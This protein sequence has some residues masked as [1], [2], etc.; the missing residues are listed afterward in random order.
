MTVAHEVILLN[1]YL[2]QTILI[3]LHMGLLSVL[4]R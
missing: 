3:F 1:W 4:Q 2:N